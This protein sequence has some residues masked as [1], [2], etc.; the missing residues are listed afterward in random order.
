LTE[1]T[2]KLLETACWMLGT[3]GQHSRF[4]CQ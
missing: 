4:N 2:G 3:F 1:M